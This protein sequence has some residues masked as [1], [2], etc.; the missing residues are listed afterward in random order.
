MHANL[1]EL[2]LCKEALE[3]MRELTS[4]YLDDAKESVK[5]VVE[6]QRW[7]DL[8]E[9]SAQ[10]TSQTED[11]KAIDYLLGWMT[12]KIADYANDHKRNFTI[13]LTNQRRKNVLMIALD[14]TCDMCDDMVWDHYPIPQ[15][16][17]P[18]ITLS[19]DDL[20][21]IRRKMD[22]KVNKLVIAT[23]MRERCAMQ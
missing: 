14:H 23:R 11:L 16:G 4:S 2:K 21:T 15:E 9:A 12:Q 18:S 8:S 5:R 1:D 19:R 20:I 6:L 13:P 17:Q 22:V 7:D 3:Y 10:V